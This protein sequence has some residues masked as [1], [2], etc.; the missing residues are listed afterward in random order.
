M[1]GFRHDLPTLIKHA[2][3]MRVHGLHGWEQPLPVV[4]P[5]P[6]SFVCKRLYLHRMTA[7]RRPRIIA[8]SSLEKSFR[9]AR[10]EK[11]ESF[12]IL[13][14]LIARSKNKLLKEGDITCSWTQ[15]FTRTAKLVHVARLASA[16]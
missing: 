6:I 16:S 11:R 7:G 12:R 2:R 8:I 9:A 13:G 14:K 10:L 5:R 3:Y 4:L 15:H 1:G